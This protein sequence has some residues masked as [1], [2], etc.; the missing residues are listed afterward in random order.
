MPARHL[1]GTT[2]RG[3]RLAAAR[4]QPML[5]L[6]LLRA[7]LTHSGGIPAGRSEQTVSVDGNTRHFIVHMPLVR[8]ASAIVL[9][10]HPSSTHPTVDALSPARA[11]E[12]YVPSHFSSWKDAG[13]I[14]VFLTSRHVGNGQHC[15]GAGTDN[16]LCSAS[17]E[18]KEDES[19][20]TLVLDW[21][22]QGLAS[23]PPTFLFGYSGGGRMAWRVGCNRSLA[24]RFSAIAST[25]AL[26]GVDLRTG[27]RCDLSSMPPTITLHGT[28]DKTTP[29]SFAETSVS[30]TAIAS[31][32][33]ST[34]NTPQ[35]GG[36][37]VAEET[38]YSSCSLASP[39]FTLAHYRLKDWPHE[40][41][42]PAWMSRIWVFWHNTTCL[43][44]HPPPASSS[45][46]SSSALSWSPS[47]GLKGIQK[48]EGGLWWVTCVL[49][50]VLVC[51]C[52]Q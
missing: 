50:L 47:S 10:L 25:S 11:F 44:S 36:N 41:A 23:V 52:V 7:S 16:N 48:G 26:M 37:P 30:W 40:L 31:A 51:V 38:C 24:Q 34:I 27:N 33:T 19:F 35:V 32:C 43:S 28:A 4:L 8:T 46:S 22:K 49:S 2:A 29:I 5:L 17:T 20:V 9:L 39:G 1:R 3:E 13:A 21:L 42:S 15:W 18:S 14:L 45:A 12:A 6:L